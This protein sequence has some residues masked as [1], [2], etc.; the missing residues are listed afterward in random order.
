MENETINNQ[1][2]GIPQILPGVVLAL[3][4]TLLKPDYG[5]SPFY[6]T[7]KETTCLDAY[8]R[9]LLL[10]YRN[11]SEQFNIVYR[12]LLK[13]FYI[14]GQSWDSIASKIGDNPDTA[15]MRVNRD[16]INALL[17]ELKKVKPSI[18]RDL[19]KEGKNGTANGV[20]DKLR[21]TVQGL[22]PKSKQWLDSFKAWYRFPYI[23]PDEFYF[24]ITSEKSSDNITLLFNALNISM[25]SVIKGSISPMEDQSSYLLQIK[26]ETSN[27]L[28]IYIVG[29]RVQPKVSDKDWDD[30]KTMSLGNQPSNALF[31]LC[32][33][34]FDIPIDLGN[35]LKPRT[36]FRLN[37]N[38]QSPAHIEFKPSVIGSESWTL[39]IP[40]GYRGR[41][42]VP[43]VNPGEKKIV[44]C[45][46]L[47]S[48]P[49]T[50]DRR[51]PV[52]G[53]TFYRN[54][55]GKWAYQTDYLGEYATGSLSSRVKVA[56]DMKDYF[57]G[58]RL[59][60]PQTEILDLYNTSS[61]KYLAF[62][63]HL[64]IPIDYPFDFAY[65]G[66]YEI[67]NQKLL[68]IWRPGVDPIRVTPDI[69]YYLE[70]NNWKRIA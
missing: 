12:P 30:I 22:D 52:I 18:S 69:V 63:G 14:D 60:P 25:P 66:V 33:G 1:L 35:A 11:G 61:S 45:E 23:P 15:R 46:P 54:N 5:F 21:G 37:D 34:L 57:R 10:G 4:E 27:V 48:F 51:K 55:Y 39:S 7:E 28:D 31:R 53:V 49:D 8:I 36:V 38:I 59:T 62:G 6:I 41:T 16:A 47:E 24:D 29:L 67:E 56:R 32:L 26:N 3:K 13:E 20:L 9:D 50:A 40:Q 43:F 17:N 68:G 44:F 19:L 58:E 64:Y 70:D 65:P 42:L 2:D